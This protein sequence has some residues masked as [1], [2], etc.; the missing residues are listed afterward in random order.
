MSKRSHSFLGWLGRQIG[1]V[2]GAV[3]KDVTPPKVLYRKTTVHE[4]PLANRPDERL[5]RTVTDEVVRN[6]PKLPPPPSK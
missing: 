5:R 6:E 1:S 3:S 4:A 2:K